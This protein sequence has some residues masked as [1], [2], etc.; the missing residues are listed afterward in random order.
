M[1]DREGCFKPTAAEIEAMVLA[2]IEA[3]R[4]ADRSSATEGQRCLGR[5]TEVLYAER[6]I[7]LAAAVGM[8]HG[9]RVLGPFAVGMALSALLAV[10]EDVGWTDPAGA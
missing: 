7:E 1:P 10:A 3:N 6:E 8:L 4:A 5:L 2:V 9:F